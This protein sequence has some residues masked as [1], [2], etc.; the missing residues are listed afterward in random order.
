MS[1][2]N[3]WVG[4]ADSDVPELVDENFGAIIT[5]DQ[6]IAV[7]RSMYANANGQVWAAGTNAAGSPLP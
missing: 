5:S 7:E 3:V 4:G 2:L 1:R 6:P